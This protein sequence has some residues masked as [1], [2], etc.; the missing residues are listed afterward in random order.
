MYRAGVE[1]ILG[2]RRA[3][4]SFSVDPCIPTTWPEFQIVWRFLDTRYEI[5]VSNPERRTRGVV[6]A[7]LDGETVNHLA[8]PL[9]NDGAV[10]HVAIVLGAASRREERQSPTRARAAL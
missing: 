10:H 8:I 1:S 6:E 4:S 9:V 2:L 5:S 7:T 3:G